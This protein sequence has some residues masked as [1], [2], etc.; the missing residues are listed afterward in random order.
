[1]RFLKKSP[2]I[3]GDFFMAAQVHETAC[4]RAIVCRRR[5]SSP[6]A[7]VPLR[8]ISKKEPLESGS[9]SPSKTVRSFGRQQTLIHFLDARI[10]FADVILETD[11]VNHRDLTATVVDQ[12]LVLQFARGF[13]HALAT[14]AEHA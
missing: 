8:T 14:H 10:A 9:T 6:L 11:A 7:P 2:A 4:M 13:G 5:Q 12:A 1:T 3:T